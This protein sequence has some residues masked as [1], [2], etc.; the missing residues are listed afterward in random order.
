MERVNP[1]LVKSI[2]DLLPGCPGLAE[3][4]VRIYFLHRRFNRLPET[5][6][7]YDVYVTPEGGICR[8][9]RVVRV[10]K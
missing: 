7:H 3:A 5:A 8:Q 4:M 1:Q 2:E 9:P 6:Q 10:M